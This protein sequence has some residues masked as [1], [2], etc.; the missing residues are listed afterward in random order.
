MDGMQLKE[1]KQIQRHKEGNK[2]RLIFFFCLFVLDVRCAGRA[3][4]DRA[5]WSLCA[6]PPCCRTLSCA[7]KQGSRDGIVLE[8]L[9]GSVL[10]RVLGRRLYVPESVREVFCPETHCGLCRGQ[11]GT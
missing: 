4:D 2:M 9:D 1:K 8:G 5:L 7:A 10:H 3:D 11:E 6:G